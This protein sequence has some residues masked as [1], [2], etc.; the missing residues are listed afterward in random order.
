MGT[1]HRFLGRVMATELSRRSL[2]DRLRGGAK[3]V[4]PPWSRPEH[5]FTDSCTLCGKC[6]G[7]CPTGILKEG[8][9]G[10]PV[11]DF[12]LGQCTF[13]GK[14]REV[15]P[16]DCFEYDAA[17]D[18]WTLKARITNGC[19]ETKGVACR[20]C[21]EACDH[22]AIGFRP[23]IGG[24]SN[25]N[26]SRGQCTGCGACVLSCPVRAISLEDPVEQE[27]FPA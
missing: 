6:I 2:F 22:G 13:C 25:P 21:E 4:R 23:R 17:R 14:C 5:I 12:D 19:V 10:Y 27:E 16:A 15:C 24:G 26:V 1:G 9:A 3:P 20:T 11:V 8:R 7:E 18:P